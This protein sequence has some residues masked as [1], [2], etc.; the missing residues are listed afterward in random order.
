MRRYD[1]PLL[2][3][4]FQLLE[5]SE[6]VLLSPLQSASIKDRFK[7]ESDAMFIEAKRSIVSTTAKIPMWFVALTILLGWNEAMAVLSN[8]VYFLMLL[9]LAGG[10]FV[11]WYTGTAGPFLSIARA[12]TTEISK[13]VGAALADRGGGKRANEAMEMK[14]RE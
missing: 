1:A 5:P 8:P 3:I 14:K 7:L 6:L 2:I 10:A 4:P 13:Q 9:L 12:M 11:I